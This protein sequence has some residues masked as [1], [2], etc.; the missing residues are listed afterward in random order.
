MTSRYSTYSQIFARSS[1]GFFVLAVHLVRITISETKCGFEN[2]ALI[3]R[4]VSS[5]I[6]NLYH[7][8]SNNHYGG[9]RISE[10]LPDDSTRV[11]QKCYLQHY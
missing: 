6:N 10:N 2:I 4:Q 9:F 3:L 7:A 5:L 8:I 1:A 11:D